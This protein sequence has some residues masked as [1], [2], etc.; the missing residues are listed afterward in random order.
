MGGP[1][2]EKSCTVSQQEICHPSLQ[3]TNENWSNSFWKNKSEPARFASRQKIQHTRWEW[4]EWID[5][6]Q[7]T[8]CLLQCTSSFAIQK[9]CFA[10]M[11]FNNQR[12]VYFSYWMHMWWT[13]TEM[14]FTLS[15]II[16]K[17]FIWYL[18]RQP[19]AEAQLDLLTR[20]CARGEREKKLSPLMTPPTKNPAELE[21]LQKGWTL[22][23]LIRLT[24]LPT[25]N[26]PSFASAEDRFKMQ[27]LLQSRSCR[28]VSRGTIFASCNS[29]QR[30]QFVVFL[31]K[32][33][34]GG[35]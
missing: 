22:F 30:A 33:K 3:S 9:L 31:Q 16:V 28:D 27:W 21:A 23:F 29:L 24:I 18:R 11:T 7:E 4:Q 14:P 32:N 12:T 20:M 25:S 17:M 2:H 1:L 35:A 8:I 6:V 5:W 26:E 13:C 34:W 19:S 15:A 10:R